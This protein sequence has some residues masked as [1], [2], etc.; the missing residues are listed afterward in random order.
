MASTLNRAALFFDHYTWQLV[1]SQF[2]KQ[3]FPQTQQ[4][5]K[6]Y[7][8]SL[9]KLPDSTRDIYCE[10]GQKDIYWHSETLFVSMCSRLALEALWF[11]FFSFQKT[12]GTLCSWGSTPKYSACLLNT[13]KS[14][15]RKSQWSL[16]LSGSRHSSWNFPLRFVGHKPRLFVHRLP[17]LH[18]LQSSTGTHD[19]KETSLRGAEIIRGS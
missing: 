1:K 4:K 7:V 5:H 11:F 2:T 13:G 6:S 15:R 14:Q 9:K 17:Q 3:R 10:T 8:S 18:T 12:Q 16:N 19:L